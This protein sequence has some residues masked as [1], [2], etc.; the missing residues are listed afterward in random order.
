M[1]NRRLTI[2]LLAAVLAAL[3]LVLAA[4]GGDDDEGAGEAA[5]QV[6]TVNWGTP[7]CAGRW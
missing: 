2:W 5:R 3:A 6:I 7:T 4:C 1:C